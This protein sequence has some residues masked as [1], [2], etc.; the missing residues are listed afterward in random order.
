MSDEQAGTGYNPSMI[1]EKWRKRWE[2]RRTNSTDLA[3]ATQPFFNLMMFPYPSAEGLH[4]GNAFAFIGADIY[5]LVQRLQGNDVF[6]PI[7]FDSFGIH[8]ENFSIKLN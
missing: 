4:V 1:E 7:V 2:E 6:E 5:G 3:R 8:S